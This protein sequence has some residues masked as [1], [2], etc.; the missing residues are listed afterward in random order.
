[1]NTFKF[2]LQ[3]AF[4]GGT[5]F[6]DKG[7]GLVLKTGLHDFYFIAI[8]AM[9]NGVV[10]PIKYFSPNFPNVKNCFPFLAR[11]LIVLKFFNIFGKSHVW[12]VIILA[13]E[14]NKM[15]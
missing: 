15:F 14:K 11:G 13:D 7:V 2:K 5:V 9:C 12:P 6:N 4:W 10:L 1:M 8:N 3:S